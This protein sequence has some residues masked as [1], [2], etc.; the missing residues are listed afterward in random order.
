MWRFHV[1]GASLRS[2]WTYSSDC[3]FYFPK[4]FQFFLSLFIYSLFYDNEAI[5]FPGWRVP[6]LQISLEPCRWLHFASLQTEPERVI[7]LNFQCQL[8]SPCFWFRYCFYCLW[9]LYGWLLQVVP[10]GC[11]ASTLCY[12]D[13]LT[14]NW[15]WSSDP[16]VWQWPEHPSG[17][18]RPSGL[19]TGS[20]PKAKWYQ[21]WLGYVLT[22]M[23]FSWALYLSL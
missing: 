17:I 3:K 8:T 19:H 11:E 20:I 22:P 23:L 12:S 15:V 4:E 6:V 9:T 16:V 18:W 5:G 13:N 2:C 10:M 7:S 1:V 14:H 21:D